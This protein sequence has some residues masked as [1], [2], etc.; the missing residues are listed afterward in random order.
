MA[1]RPGGDRRRH[2]VHRGHHRAQARGGGASPAGRAEARRRGAA[3]GR[4]PQGRVPGHAGARAAQSAGPHRA[5][6]GDDPHER[7]GRRIHQLGARGHRPPGG[8]ADAAGGRSARRLAH[9][10]GQDQAE[11]VGAGPRARHRAGGGVHPAAVRR[12]RPRAVARPARPAAA[13]PRR[14]RAVDAD[15]LQPAQQRREVHRRGRSH[16]AR[17]CGRSARRSSCASRTT[18]TASR[19]TCSSGCSTC[20][21]SSKGRA[22][23]AI[24]RQDGLGIGLALVK[25]LVEMHDGEIEARSEGPGRGSEFVV[26]LPIGGRPGRSA[27]RRRRRCRPRARRRPGPRRE[28]ILVVDDN[29][30]AAE[31]LSR[32][33][34]AAGARGAG[35]ARRPGG[36]GGRAAR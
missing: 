10:A 15:H 18:A 30:D 9:H 28:R 6:R 3:G 2:D 16:H 36:A 26:R 12:P 31:S 19:R 33:S 21:R 13:D 29:V 34:A 22:M 24:A 7:A 17:A 11:P 23:R 4:P 20:S 14:R 5:G 8:A 27:T 1:R 25:R 35:R 32:M